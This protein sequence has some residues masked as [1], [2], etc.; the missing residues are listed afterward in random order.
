MKKTLFCFL[1]FSFN[2]SLLQ[3][4]DTLFLRNGQ[5]MGVKVVSVTDK[6]IYTVPP[7][8]NPMYIKSSKVSYIK[9]KDGSI[10]TCKKNDSVKI[11]KPY[12][13]VSS[14]LSS[15][16]GSYSGN[17][18][19]NQDPPEEYSY[20]GYASDG[21]TYGVTAGLNTK[22]GWEIT[23]MF[24][25]Y[26]HPMDAAGFIQEN[27]AIFMNGT[28]TSTPNGDGIVTVNKSSTAN[29]YYYNNSSFL[30]GIT[31]NWGTPNVSLGISMMFGS[32]TSNLPDIT[33]HVTYQ[34]YN[35][36]NTDTYQGYLNTVSNQEHHFDFDMNL[37]I[38][39]KVWMHI[40]A[41]A[42]FDVQFSSTNTGTGYELINYNGNVVQQGA[43][44][45]FNEPTNLFI[46]TLNLT[47]GVGY[48]F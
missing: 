34:I 22:W 3:A 1:L 15:P 25:E 19:N 31:K 5:K 41:R 29:K 37:H 32:L 6:V 17:S 35:Y 2:F 40:F 7:D 48:E 44:G 39:V 46:G 26:K 27:A 13:L 42:M 23:A 10:Y 9:Y 36:P 20:S 33:S 30:I 8:D 18:Y 11:V 43:F 28:Y 45:R 38:N 14:G 24:N 12:L 47:G 21:Y 16:F 4:Q